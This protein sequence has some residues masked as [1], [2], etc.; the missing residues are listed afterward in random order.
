MRAYYTI[1]E[2]TDY[3]PYITK[4]ILPV[5]TKVKADAVKPECFNVY[6]ERKDKQGNILML[7]KHF[8]DMDN[9]EPS[10]G[11]C[12]IR[13]AYPSTL[14][15]ERREEAEF[16]TL[17]TVY[18]PNDSLAAPIAPING[19]NVYIVQDIRIT[20]IAEMAAESGKVSGLVFDRCAGNT[21]KQAE[22]FLHG[23]SSYEPE[24]LKYGYFVPQTGQGKRPLIIWLHGGGEGGDDPTIAYTANKV[25]NLASHAIQAKFGGSYVLV[26]Q[27][28]T[29]WLD[30]GSGQYGRSGKSK[31]VT[32]LKAVID[33]FIVNNDAAID[34]DRIYIGGCSN[35]GFMTMRM[36]IDFPDF[37]AAAF[38]VCEA[39]Y[40][41]VI[42]DEDIESIKHMPIWFTHSKD[43]NVVKPEETVVPTYERLIRAGAKNVHFSYFDQ[44]V[45]LHGVF[46]G[47]NEEPFR[48]HGHFSWIYA[49][50]DDCR[51]D[52]DGKPV[53]VNG[54]EVTMM[55]WLALQSKA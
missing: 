40:D 3:G 27:A 6:V 48:Y 46:Q 14:E 13:D 37:F 44:V 12:K 53:T 43:D 31:Y 21:V 54:K 5:G 41:E 1:T 10:K 52:Y 18:G 20:Q 15:G 7:P 42:S 39:L 28:P 16:V 9:K 30:D 35:G 25:V 55:D 23:I 47:D 24:P 8:L 45:D 4:L 29:F 11:Y 33:E 49:L 32:A 50:N 2:I 34:R 17:E 38:P 26:P 51:L 19:K 36:V 22:H